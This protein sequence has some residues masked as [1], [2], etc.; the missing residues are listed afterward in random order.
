[1]GIHLL[2]IV[3]LS[4]VGIFNF[5]GKRFQSVDTNVLY[6]FSLEVNKTFEHKDDLIFN[7][8]LS[9]SHSKVLI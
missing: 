8:N 2:L 9:F 4:A 7:L 1:M 6:F 5:S 3:K